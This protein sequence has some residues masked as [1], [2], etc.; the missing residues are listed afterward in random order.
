MPRSILFISAPYLTKNLLSYELDQELLLPRH[1]VRKLQDIML[2]NT[3]ILLLGFIMGYPL[4]Q[5]QFKRFDT[6][7]NLYAPPLSLWIN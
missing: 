6:E 5:T 2:W 3:R 1:A 7:D 4:Y